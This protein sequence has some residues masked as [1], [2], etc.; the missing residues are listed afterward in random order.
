MALLGSIFGGVFDALGAGTD[1][2][3]STQNNYTSAVNQAGANY[4]N[5]QNQSASQFASAQNAQTM[6]MYNAGVQAEVQNAQA[7]TQTATGMFDTKYNIANMQ[8]GYDKF[9]AEFGDIQDNIYGTMRSLSASSRNAQ[10]HDSLQE[11]MQYEMQN[12][13]QRFT[14]LGI[15]PSSGMYQAA[16]ML[17]RNNAATE[18]VKQTRNT[19][20]ELAQIKSNFIN[21]E[22]NQKYFSRAEDF[23][24]GILNQD[25]LNKFV[26]EADISNV[27][28]GGVAGWTPTEQTD[29]QKAKTEKF[30]GIF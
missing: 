14:E 23:D 30:L 21:N 11:N 28:M 20:V 22:A 13:Q 24:K 8:A 16:N 9:Q 5:A 1:R 26:T 4:V 18:E 17:L 29:I 3:Q 27:E 12:T 25:E 2:D 10:I 19:E 7:Y 15:N 6:A